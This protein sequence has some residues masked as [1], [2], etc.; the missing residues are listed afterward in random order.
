MFFINLS[1]YRSWI[2]NSEL[3]IRTIKIF[4]YKL[5]NLRTQML[6]Q[7]ILDAIEFARG[8]SNSKWGSVR[9]AMGHTEPFDLRYVAVGNQDCGNKNYRGTWLLFSY[10]TNYMICNYLLYCYTS[11]GNYNK[12]Y[13]AIK[14]VFPNMKIISNCDGSNQLLDHPA[15]L[16]DFHVRISTLTYQSLHNICRTVFFLST[17]LS[18]VKV[19]TNAN[20]MFSMAHNFDH[21]SRRGPKVFGKSLIYVFLFSEMLKYSIWQIILSGFCEWVRGNWKGCR[22]G[23]SLKGACWGWFSYWPRDK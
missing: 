7:D 10:D 11:S 22:K 16:Y 23:K 12:F 3:G 20:S 13:N 8:D 14:R 21:T 2:K 19:Y 17:L 5:L 4:V 1:L 9:A 15:D 6:V 18:C